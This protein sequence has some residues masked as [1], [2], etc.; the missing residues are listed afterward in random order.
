MDI[1]DRFLG[2]DVGTTTRFIIAFAVVFVLV[3]LLAWLLK[4]LSRGISSGEKRGRAPR[5]AILEAIAV[6][7]RRRLVL[8]RRDNMEHLLLL[9][10][11]SDL[12]VEQAIARMPRANVQRPADP[13]IDSG[14]RVAPPGAG[15]TAPVPV[16]RPEP[17]LAPSPVPQPRGENTPA[18]QRPAQRLPQPSVP[19][20]D[21]KDDGAQRQL[22]EMAERLEMALRAPG[23]IHPAP[24]AAAAPPASPQA[25]AP[26]LR[27]SADDRIGRA[28]RTAAEQQDV[29]PATEAESAA[30][31]QDNRKP[32][33][34]FGRLSRRSSE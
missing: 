26:E 6:D 12:V 21:D 3:L 25:T 23:A 27:T 17:R 28:G 24:V 14:P 33:S 11:P 30:S 7:Q 4:R 29:A 1:L 13:Q 22:A 9:G 32:G 20:D 31:S 10:G 34:L 8:V 16:A 5:L 18:Q 19:A 2:P 15:A